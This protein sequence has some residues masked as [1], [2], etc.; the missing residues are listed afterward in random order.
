[1]SVG[2]SFSNAKQTLRRGAFAALT[3]A[4]IGLAAVGIVGAPEAHA[5]QATPIATN[6]ISPEIAREVDARLKLLAPIIRS[7]E[8]E[9]ERLRIPVAQRDDCAAQTILFGRTI[10]ALKTDALYAQVLAR[11]DM[12]DLEN[13]TRFATCTLPEGLNAKLNVCSTSGMSL[14]GKLSGTVFDPAK[15]DIRPLEV[16]CPSLP[17]RQATLQPAAGPQRA[18]PRP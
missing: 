4:S 6:A 12:H 2:T 10:M 18:A 1:M 14:Q 5:Q 13:M 11:A 15:M 3:A 9:R 8:A 17:G 16:R 7:A